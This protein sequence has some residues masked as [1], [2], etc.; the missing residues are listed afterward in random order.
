[1]KGNSF[2]VNER[3]KSRKLIEKLF[4]EGQS[5]A[6]YPLRLV[7]L[8]TELPEG[9]GPIQAA[10]SVSKKNFRSAVSRNRIR[11]QMREA[12]RLKKEPLAHLPEQFAWMILYVAK[13][14]LPYSQIGA[15][16]ESLIK[17]FIKKT[18]H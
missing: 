12:Y 16:M 5:F 11:R 4:S 17:K 2:S 7:Y 10:F 9:G 18:A 13:E 1:M 8:K 6:V 3:L 14:P 15:A